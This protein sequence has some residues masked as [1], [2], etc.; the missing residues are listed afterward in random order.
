[1]QNYHA[2]LDIPGELEWAVVFVGM[3]VCIIAIVALAAVLLTVGVHQ[4]VFVGWYE[5]PKDNAASSPSLV[6]VNHH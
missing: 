4:L 5:S 2:P 1:M 3:M 6:S